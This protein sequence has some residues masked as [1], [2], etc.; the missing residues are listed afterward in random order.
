M[1]KIFLIAF[2]ALV[3]VGQANAA[4]FHWADGNGHYYE[5]VQTSLNWHDAKIAAEEAHGYLAVITTN[6]ENLFVWDTFN[7]PMGAWLGGYQHPDVSLP[8]GSWNWI[9]D[10]GWDWTEWQPGEPN[11]GGDG[12]ED[13][14]ENH[15]GYNSNYDYRTWGDFHYSNLRKYIVEY[16]TN[17]SLVPIPAAFWLFCSGLLG[18][19]G[20]ARRKKAA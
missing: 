4:L 13:N 8:Y 10:D 11:D 12:V 14:A 6:A 7:H 5:Y 19:I 9:T 1:K 16:D 2:G 20:L 3:M 17:P 18:L 15:L